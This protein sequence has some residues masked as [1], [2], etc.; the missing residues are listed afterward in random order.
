MEIGPIA[1][2]LHAKRRLPPRRMRR[3]RRRTRNRCEFRCQANNIDGRLTFTSIL[4]SKPLKRSAKKADIN[5]EEAA[6]PAK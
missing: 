3:L 5:T 1:R 4:P 2:R 6:E